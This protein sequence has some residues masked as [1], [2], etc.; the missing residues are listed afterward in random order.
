MIS[1]LSITT[2]VQKRVHL[3]VV[4]LF[5]TLTEKD[6]IGNCCECFDNLKYI[7]RVDVDSLM[8]KRMLEKQELE[9]D[10]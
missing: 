7:A 3:F 10:N 4:N 1:C 6:V 8:G 9:V 2:Y 5:Y